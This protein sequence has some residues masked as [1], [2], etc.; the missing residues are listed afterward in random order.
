[1]LKIKGL[2]LFAV[3]VFLLQSCGGEDGSS[4]D[5]EKKLESNQE[6]GVH[7]N[8]STSKKET[9]SEKEHFNFKSDNDV[10]TY[11]I[12]KQFDASDS[13]LYMKFETYGADV[14]GTKYEWINHTAISK[15]KAFIKLAST[16]TINPDCVITVWIDC[17]LHTVTDGE[18]V[19]MYN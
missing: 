3:S 5:I 18:T 4:R 14:S 12:G 9:S 13:D 17:H 7:A 15:N 16:S 1:M 6:E 2:V 11:L 8:A 19:L 10:L